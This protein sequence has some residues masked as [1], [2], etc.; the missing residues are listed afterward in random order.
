MIRFFKSLYLNNRFFLLFGTI[1]VVFIFCFAAPYL[2]VFAQ[3]LFITA[4][5]LCL[6][7]IIILFNH[8]NYIECE[9]SLPKSMSLGDENNIDIILNNKSSIPLNVKL[10]DEI[11]IQ[12]QERNHSFS[13]TLLANEKKKLSYQL[14]PVTRGEYIFGKINIFTQTKLALVERKYSQNK[15]ISVP[16]Y[17]SVIQMKKYGLKA[18]KRI[19]THYGIKKIRR[20]GHSYEFE[21]IKNYVKGDDYRSINWKATSRS[22]NLMVNQY[23]DEKAQQVYSIID[24][25]RVMKMPFNEMSLLDYAI[26]TSLVISNASLQ[27]HDKAGLITFSDKI[28][29]TIKAERGQRQLQ[30]IMDSLY[31]Q[32]ERK[33]EANYELMYLATKNFIKG[34]SLVFLYTNFESFYSLERVLPVLR[35]INQFHLLVV[36]FF[37]N[38]EILEFSKKESKD[39]EDIYHQTIAEKFIL[40]KY[41]MVNQL[42]KYGIQSVLNS[43]ENLSINTINKYLELKSRGLI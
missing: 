18:M 22:N 33:N 21:T 14:R 32:E 29:T 24:K 3:T 23:E 42:K 1:A 36:M 13:F 35:K 15:E 19:S 10:I 34:R 27:K 12:F 39:I 38:T 11:P 28:G 37:E 9:R 17:P 16:V 5:A 20:L 7:D 43:P 8:N 41:R 26:N 2:M 31:N 40:E 30:K 25:S 4:V 6:V